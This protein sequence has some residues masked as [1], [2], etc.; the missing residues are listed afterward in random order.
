MGSAAA[1]QREMGS[2]IIWEGRKVVL[3]NVESPESVQ[4]ARH[5]KEE[6]IWISVNGNMINPADH[7]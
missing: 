5:K 7:I 2:L 3:L 4:F 6:L 1:G